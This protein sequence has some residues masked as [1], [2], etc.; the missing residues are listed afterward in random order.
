MFTL[1]LETSTPRGSLAVLHQGKVIFAEEFH[2]E[3]GHS[4]LLFDLLERARAAVPVF[5][6]VVIGLGPGSYAGIRIAIA[7]GVGL[8]LA[9]DAELLGI[10]SPAGLAVQVPE[11]VVV[12]DA[13]RETFYWCHVEQG[14]CRQG[15][16]LITQVELHLRLADLRLPCYT[17]E[18]LP[19]APGAGLAFPSALTLARQ[20][21][22]GCGVTAHGTLEPLYLREPHITH[23]KPVAGLGMPPATV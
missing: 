15:P 4:S 20:A 17:S 14:V 5:H 9:M 1:A 6:R 22:T 13:R 2:A 16:E 18:P 7:A 11:Y 19:Q 23:A 10:P 3:R 12:G 21:E 8:Q